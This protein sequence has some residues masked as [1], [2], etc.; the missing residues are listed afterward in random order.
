MRRNIISSLL[1]FF[2]AI[3]A[4]AALQ[5]GL[6]YDFSTVQA[7]PSATSVFVA[8][9]A[10]L[11]DDHVSNLTTTSHVGNTHCFTYC[12]LAAD[13]RFLSGSISIFTY[14]HFNSLVHQ[15]NASK[16]HFRPPI[17]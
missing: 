11:V 8:S 2:V 10:N 1:W 3:Y 15:V 6:L 4:V 7:A 12:G 9:N 13:E 5:Q 16:Q 14:R 17:A